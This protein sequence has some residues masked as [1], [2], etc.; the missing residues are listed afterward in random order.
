MRVERVRALATAS[1]GGLSPRCHFPFAWRSDRDGLSS[2]HSRCA[3]ACWQSERCTALT[4][5]PAGD[6]PTGR[7]PPAARWASQCSQGRVRT[8]NRR[9]RQRAA[10]VYPPGGTLSEQF[11]PAPADLRQTLFE[12]GGCT[13]TKCILRCRHRGTR[14]DKPGG[15]LRR[16][17][18]RA[19]A[20]APAARKAGRGTLVNR[21]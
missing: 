2:S 7:C 5:A 4:A 1:R 14:R 8:R 12:T 16:A 13:L 18:E 11:V 17:S 20:S 15:S 6:H 10:G 9:S 19:P 3:S 21:R